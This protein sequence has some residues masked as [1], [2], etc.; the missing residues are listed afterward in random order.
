MKTL[1]LINAESLLPIISYVKL[2]KLDVTALLRESG[3]P[4]DLADADCSIKAVANYQY[5]QFIHL[6]QKQLNWPDFGYRMAKDIKLASMKPIFKTVCD[7]SLTLHDGLIMLIRFMSHLSTHATYDLA[8][9]KSGVWF[10]GTGVEI[11]SDALKPLEQMSLANMI[12]F[13]RYYLGDTW[14]PEAITIQHQDV[15]S[16]TRKYFPQALVTD[17][18]AKTGIFINSAHVGSINARF[19]LANMLADSDLNVNFSQK[20]YQVLSQYAGLGFPTINKLSEL[21]GLSLRQIQRRLVKE[22]VSYREILNQVKFD[23]ARKQLS[24]SNTKIIDISQQLDYTDAS[25]FSRA[26]KKMAN[27]SPK[28]Y[29]A[30]H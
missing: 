15:S 6:C 10:Y 11:E 2:Q 25:H 5:W 26:F 4:F 28:Q 8:Y 7:K 9:Q 12:G 17:L 23:I 3:L 21:I 20:L 22:E 27:M 18:Q 14:Q 24:Q 19:N 13:V 1:H 16:E 30:I 29:R